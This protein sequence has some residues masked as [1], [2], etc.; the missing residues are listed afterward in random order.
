MSFGTERFGDLVASKN[1]GLSPGVYGTGSVAG[2]VLQYV[3]ARRLTVGLIMG[4]V[5]SGNA[6][7]QL[8]F[9]IAPLSTGTFSTVASTAA[10]VGS[11]AST[12]QIA[13]IDT[14][15]EA[16]YG[17][18]GSYGVS[19]LNAGSAAGVG[20]Q[21]LTA[22]AWCRC[23]L[24][25]ANSTVTCGIIALGYLLPYEARGF[26]DTASYATYVDFI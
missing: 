17:G 18:G 11:V 6:T 5:G 7:A 3:Q 12:A 20:G 13:W 10:L 23:V 25:V 24:S 14:R 22:P 15:G 8:L 1:M 9:Q 21:S 26:D 19:G 2:S 16:I 4:S